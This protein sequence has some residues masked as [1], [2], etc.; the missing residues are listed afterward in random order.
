[1]AGHSHTHPDPG[2]DLDG[3]VEAV[4]DRLRAD[5]GRV[6]SGRR[7]I[8]LSLLS[9]RDHHVTADD[10]A[11]AVQLDHPDLHLSTIYRTLEALE[12]LGVVTRADLGQGR[13]VY[14][15]V[16]RAH[17]H[18]V[19]VDCGRIDDL[20]GSFPGVPAP[21]DRLADGFEVTATEI[22]F[23]GRCAT[24]STAPDRSPQHQGVAH[25]HG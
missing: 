17:H 21:A 8:V 15:P 16:E 18:L 19:C 13:A 23:R 1:M 3:R 7:A 22:V 14:H 25:A 2:N 9:A 11:R 12:Q 4:L 10:L 24:C 5:G 6:T 20:P